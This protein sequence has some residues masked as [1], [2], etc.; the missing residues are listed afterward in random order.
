MFPTAQVPIKTTH[1]L[2]NSS[3]ILPKKSLMR[4][5]LTVWKEPTGWGHIPIWSVGYRKVLLRGRLRWA[6]CVSLA[7]RK[8]IPFLAYFINSES[9]CNLHCCLYCTTKFLMLHTNV[10]AQDSFDKAWEIGTRKL[11]TKSSESC[12]KKTTFMIC[13]HSLIRVFASS[14]KY[15]WALGFPYIN[16]WCLLS[17]WH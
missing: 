14:I 11:G 5:F 1:R 10:W 4:V 15:L 13:I 12:L 6:F 8:I 7:C 17:H 2:E 16:Y 3:K 9:W